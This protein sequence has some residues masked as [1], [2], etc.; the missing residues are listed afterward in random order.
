MGITISE[1]QDKTMLK[2]AKT[3]DANQDGIIENDEISIFV[4]NLLKANFSS[5]EINNLLKTRYPEEE[6]LISRINELESAETRYNDLNVKE[7]WK[8]SPLGWFIGIGLGAFAG[9]SS[10][11]ALMKASSTMPGK[12]LGFASAFVFIFGGGLA[13]EKIGD[14][15]MLNKYKKARNE[16]EN[17]K[18]GFITDIPEH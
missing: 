17:L 10:A 18:E 1:I 5:T 15:I 4:K 9:V 16:Y 3:A 6:E 8:S 11:K 7:G 12:L 13:G 2:Y 14:S